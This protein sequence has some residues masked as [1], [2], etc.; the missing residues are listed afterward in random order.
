MGEEM[1]NREITIQPDWIDRIDISQFCQ[2]AAIGFT[3]RKIAA[4]FKI[5]ES[6]FMD[7]YANPA[8]N[9][10]NEYLSAV[11]NY[12]G[13]EQQQMLNDSIAGNATQGQRLDKKR[14]ETKFE[15]LKDRIIYGKEI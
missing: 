2:L 10:E 9:L 11:I 14:F 8:S 15:M 3:P 5:P 12:T 6:D 4:Y 1:E 7:W 13:K